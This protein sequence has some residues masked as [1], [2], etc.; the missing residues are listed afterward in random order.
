M[1][2]LAQAAVKTEKYNQLSAELRLFQLSVLLRKLDN[3][4][5]LK[6]TL[7]ARK[8]T[9]ADFFSHQ[10]AILSSREAEAVQVQH[11]LDELS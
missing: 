11:R 9:A 10:A 1:E 5:S 6:Q 4:E 2:P 3:M 7:E 8:A